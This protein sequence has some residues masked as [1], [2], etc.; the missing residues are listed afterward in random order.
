M[1]KKQYLHKNFIKFLLKKT[2]KKLTYPQMN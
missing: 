1:K 2:Q